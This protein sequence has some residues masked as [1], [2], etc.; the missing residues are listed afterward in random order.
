[1]L[2]QSTICL[3]LFAKAIKC[4]TANAAA[5]LGK[6][7]GGIS[8]K[9]RLN[10]ICRTQTP[11]SHH[12]LFSNLTIK[13]ICSQKTLITSWR[14]MQSKPF[15]ISGTV[16]SDTL[17]FA[18]KN[19]AFYKMFAYFGIFQMGMW[20]YLSLFAFQ[21][22]KAVPVGL[23]DTSEMPWYKRLLYKQ[24]HYKNA[25]SLLSFIVGGVVLFITVAY[26]RRV[27]KSLYLLKGGDHVKITTYSW[28]GQTRT[29]TKPVDHLS[30]MEARTGKGPHI[31]V[32]IRDTNFYYIIDKQ[33]SF[34]KTDLFDF[35]VGVKRNF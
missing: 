35:V 27:I 24:G 21:Q 6:H 34:P 15:N 28:L 17:L 10:L 3:S 9:L 11:F 32:K 20:A 29:F 4:E 31:P 19:D 8:S 26:P 33:G 1:M 23:Q 22:L 25:L 2:R 14:S 13:S 5:S 12:R 30:C 18:H 16:K 7:N